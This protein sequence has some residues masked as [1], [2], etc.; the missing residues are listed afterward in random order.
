MLDVDYVRG[1]DAKLSGSNSILIES[2]LCS[3]PKAIIKTILFSFALMS[4]HVC[5]QYIWC[6]GF[7]YSGPH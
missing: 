1:E 3:G 4:T 6:H 5:V 7:E 2:T